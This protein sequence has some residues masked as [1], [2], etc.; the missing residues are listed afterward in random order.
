MMIPT[1]AMIR[2]PGIVR[3]K[4][5]SLRRVDPPVS[6]V[7]PKADSMIERELAGLVQ[8]SRFSFRKEIPPPSEILRKRSKVGWNLGHLWDHMLERDGFLYGLWCKRW[9][10]VLGLP[11]YIL[12]ADETPRAKEIAHFCRLA[13]SEVPSFHINLRHQFLSLTHGWSADEIMWQH[14]TAG[15]ISGKWGLDLIDRPMSRFLYK[16]DCRLYVRRPDGNHVAAPDGKFLV[17]R[18]GSKDNPWGG[19]GLLHYLYWYWFAG[20]H[21]WKYF[22]ILIEKWAQPTAVGKYNRVRDSKVNEANVN[23]LFQAIDQIQT[24]YSI[25]IPDDLVVTLLEAKRGGEVSYEKFISLAN[26]AKALI[27]LG[28]AD[29]SGMEQGQGSFA[30]RRVSNDVRLETI[31]IDAHELDAHMTDNLLRLLVEVN[32]G[33]DAPVPFW[34]TEVDDAED[35][36]MR[37][38]RADAM[39]DRG[40]PLPLESYYHLN[41]QRL[42]REGESII[43]S[44]GDP[45]VEVVD[46]PEGFP[47]PRTPE[48]LDVNPTLPFTARAALRCYQTGDIH[49]YLLA[50]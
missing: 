43:R 25:V 41:K 11:R 50:A 1:P 18:T 45:S 9:K 39:L 40:L 3:R 37:Q 33:A 42:P 28:E 15:K 27:I 10:A 13:L 19:L 14:R 26:L 29:T 5:A 32:F 24:E 6:A 22:H 7:V 38:E 21:G 47:E 36:K 4:R 2:R 16:T 12:P 49:D 44:V 8:T 35:L 48:S 17:M 34:F 23:T 31:R 30:R 46:P 20:E